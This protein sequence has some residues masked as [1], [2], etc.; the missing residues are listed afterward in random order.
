MPRL[1]SW[2]IIIRPHTGD[3]AGCVRVC[4]SKVQEGRA[5]VVSL[6]GVQA[7]FT[8]LFDTEEDRWEQ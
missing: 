8:D 1:D 5:A 4:V 3:D 6:C 7:V 2:E